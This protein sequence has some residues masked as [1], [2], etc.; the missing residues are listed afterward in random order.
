MALLNK[1]LNL[2]IRQ[3][4]VDFVMPDVEVDRRLG[5]DPFLLYRSPS[6]DFQQAHDK[7]L[8]YFNFILESIREGNFTR[9]EYLLQCPEP[10]EIGLGYSKQGNRG[11]GVGP[12][13]A[14]EI[15][16]TF[17]N[18]PILLSRGLR[19]IEEL[20]LICPGVGP[21]RISDIAANILKLFFIEYTQEQCHSWNIPINRDIPINHYY[22]YNISDWH[23]GYFN[24]PINPLTGGA[25]LFVPRRILRI[26]PWINYDDYLG[27]YSRAFLKP[28]SRSSSLRLKSKSSS[29]KKDQAKNT[30]K[31]T[32]P[33]PQVCQV[34][35]QNTSALDTY[36]EKKEREA[37][38]AIPTELVSL[39]DIEKLKEH[40]ASLIKELTSITPG[41]EDA[42]EYQDIV[43]RILTFCFH[44]HLTDGTPQERTYEG[45]LIRDLVFTNEGIR[46][47]WHYI[48]QTFGSILI[49]FELKNKTD[50]GGSDVDQIATYLGDTMGRFGILV[51]R[52][53]KGQT[54]FKRRKTIF[55]KDSSRKVILHLTDKDLLE[56]LNQRSM[57]RDT[58]DYLQNVFRKFMVSIE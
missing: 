39:Q 50:I 9:A 4:D 34:T 8:K 31:E 19:H 47:F 53:D 43:H 18:S 1:V 46:N 40:A 22:D 54:S 44:P 14:K 20:Q 28:V 41:K 52:S 15:S 3:E 33:K 16:N 21:D 25:L 36:I 6:S 24:L 7:I 56:L 13:L 35:S 49:V 55:N 51:S 12:E 30:A 57:L 32:V 2:P 48:M 23:D 11:N 37:A 5:I 38:N 45:T 26:L 29:Q 17:C 27:E 42:Y 10:N 58:T